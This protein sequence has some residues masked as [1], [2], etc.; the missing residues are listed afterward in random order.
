V[1]KRHDKTE[2]KAW[3]DTPMFKRAEAI[4]HALVEAELEAEMEG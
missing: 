2:T 3:K 4:E 1:L